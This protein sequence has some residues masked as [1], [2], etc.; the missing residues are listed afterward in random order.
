M[1][2]KSLTG[3]ESNWR[4]WKIAANIAAVGLFCFNFAYN[5]HQLS[6]LCASSFM[7]SSGKTS[8]QKKPPPLHEYRIPE[9]KVH[10]P[11][12]EIQSSA[13]YNATNITQRVQRFSMS[14][15]DTWILQSDGAKDNVEG[16]YTLQFQMLECPT[17]YMASTFHVQS[18]TQQS[19]FTG[20]VGPRYKVQEGCGFYNVSVPIVMSPTIINASI[21]SHTTVKTCGEVG[22]PSSSVAIE[23]FWTSRFRNYANRLADRKMAEKIK[24][25]KDNLTSDDIAQMVG[26]D[27]LQYL[28]RH[29]DVIPGFPLALE[30]P[31]SE[32]F[33]LNSS[34]SSNSKGHNGPNMLPNCSEV[35]LA[36]WLPVGVSSQSDNSP[37][38]FQSTKCHYTTWTRDDLDY[39]LAGL[40][41]KYLGDSHCH[42]ESINVFNIICPEANS[43][44]QF[45]KDQYDCPQQ[46]NN[47]FSFGNRFYRGIL[48]SDGHDMDGLSKG[49]REVRPEAC[50]RF[51]GVGLYNVTIITT[52]TWLFV[53]EIEEGLHDY[54]QSLRDII[55]LCR[56]LHPPEM[57]DLIILLQS[58]TAADV[59]PSK[60]KSTADEW[61]QNHNFREEEFTHALYNKLDGLVD[62]VIPVFPW[63]LARNWRHKTSDGVHQTG[64]YYSEV[65]HLQSSA[66]IS[67]MKFSK[68]WD[69]PLMSMD[70]NR[71]HWFYG[72]PMP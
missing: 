4:G 53:Y 10:S 25:G 14:H 5:Y 40:R 1:V 33:G 63:T 9:F 56:R 7:G 66:I 17:Q 43:S 51:L 13:A 50:A 29:L 21:D 6:S 20:T 69:V 34:S 28:A 23:A 48:T 32:I 55:Q 26:E 11:C 24:A 42:F 54:V 47:T 58:P 38:Q 3:R 52:P 67:A 30:L 70:D 19:I 27:R 59:F 46:P 62:G 44:Q 60:A 16:G 41:I 45:F 71:T 12:P 39:W 68:G 64:T 61:R 49:M 22:I 35:P 15:I 72:V 37:W 65:F 31:P 2:Q 57:K 18:T 36:D 8:L